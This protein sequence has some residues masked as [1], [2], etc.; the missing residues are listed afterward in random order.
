MGKGK[1]EGKGREGVREEGREGGRKGG[2][3]EGR[4]GGL[5]EDTRTINPTRSTYHAFLL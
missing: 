2:G 5:R 3:E 4:E 1:Y